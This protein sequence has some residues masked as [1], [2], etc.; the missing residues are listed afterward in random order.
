MP[1]PEFPKPDPAMTQDQ[2]LNMILSS[3]ALEE[4]ALSH[5]LDAEGEKLQYILKTRSNSSC[6]ASTSEILA[7]NKSV[8]DL[9]EMVMQNQLLLKNK[10]ND[11]LEYLPKP[12]P[13]RDM[14]PCCCMPPG[15]PH[16]QTCPPPPCP[17]MVKENCFEML[18][19]CCLSDHAFRWKENTASRITCKTKQEKID[20][21]HTG[22]FRFEFAID[23]SMLAYGEHI[24]SVELIIDCCCEKQAI[25]KL[26][27]MPDCCK[28]KIFTG[29][30]AIQMPCSCSPCTA[31]LFLRSPERVQIHHGFLSVEEV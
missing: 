11:V 5:I 20:L 3:I 15:S 8:T 25:H 27:F 10:M 6:P 21:P 13:C 17:P 1:I 12:P 26:F 14:P 30:T 23:F 31:S 7:I 29:C 18:P 2:A 16:S 4:L 28:K 22:T 9:L 19:G 24:L